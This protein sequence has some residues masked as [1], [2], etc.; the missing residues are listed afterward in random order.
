ML[1][2][3][4]VTGKLVVVC[5]LCLGE[6]LSWFIFLLTLS[7]D[8]RGAVLMQVGDA[9]VATVSD[10]V[11]VCLEIHLGVFEQLEV[12]CFAWSKVSCD[13]FPRLLVD[14][15]LALGSMALLLARVVASLSF[16]GRS[17][18]DSLASMRA[19]SMTAS[20]F[21]RAFLPGSANNLS[22]MSVSSTQRL[23]R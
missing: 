5:P 4:A 2:E 22:L 11:G 6:W 13:D 15:Y 21:T 18:G 12:M 17:T 16:F 10:G 8:R 23:I 19:I 1:I 20:D 14:D 9:L 3:Y 7:F